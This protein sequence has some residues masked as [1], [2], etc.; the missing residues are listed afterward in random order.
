MFIDTENKTAFVTDTAVLVTRNL[1]NTEAEKNYRIWK[2]NVSV[3]PLVILAEVE[4]TK[5]FLK[6]IQNTNSTKST[7]RVGQCYY[8]R[9][10]YYA[11][12]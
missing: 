2:L 3:Y 4:V 9:V 12:S 7:L 5:S 6:Y 10:I 11:N 1:P 8:K